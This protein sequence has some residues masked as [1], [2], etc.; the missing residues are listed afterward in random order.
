MAKDELDTDA[1]TQIGNPVPG[2]DTLN[3]KDRIVAVGL[4]R[5][6]VSLGCGRHITVHTDCSVMIHDADVHGSCVQVDATVELML[7]RVESHTAS[8]ILG[9]DT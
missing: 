4:E 9:M 3:G 6:G 8:S 5:I 7:F 1:A 2:E